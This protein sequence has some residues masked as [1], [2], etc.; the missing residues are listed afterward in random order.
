MFYYPETS[1]EKQ[2]L[3]LS[4]GCGKMP[5]GEVPVW[6]VLRCLTDKERRHV[7]F[8][9]WL[10]QKKGWGTATNGTDKNRTSQ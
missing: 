10:S 3:Y 4:G 6:G 7:D 5:D 2:Y 8:I 1:D 9:S